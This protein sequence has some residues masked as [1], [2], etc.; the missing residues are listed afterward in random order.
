[1]RQK[2]TFRIPLGILAL[3]VVLTAYVLAV[4]WASQWI[5]QLHVLIQTPIYIVLG[6]V[7]IMPLGRFMTWMETGRWRF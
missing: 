3:L 5:G 2:P 7:W 4:V 6:T 1:M